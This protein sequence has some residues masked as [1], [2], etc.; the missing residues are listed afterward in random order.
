MIRAQ[1]GKDLGEKKPYRQRRVII[2]ALRH[3]RCWGVQEAEGGAVWLELC[4][5][6]VGSVI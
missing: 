4:N 1:P 2:K 5:W 3:E 6:G